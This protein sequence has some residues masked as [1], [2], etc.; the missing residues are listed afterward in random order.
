MNKKTYQDKKVTGVWGNAP[1]F[2]RA[3][4]EQEEILKQISNLFQMVIGIGQRPIYWANKK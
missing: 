4:N 3:K 2:G 1:F